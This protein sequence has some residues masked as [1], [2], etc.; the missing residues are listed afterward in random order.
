[1]KTREKIRKDRKKVYQLLK[2][3]IDA[4]FLFQSIEERSISRKT[5]CIKKSLLYL[6]SQ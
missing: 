3:T 2:Y 6:W 5:A 1:M 4:V